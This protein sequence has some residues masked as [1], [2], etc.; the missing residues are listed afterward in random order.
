MHRIYECAKKKA[1]A[2]VEYGINERNL[3]A[4]GELVDICKDIKQME[5]W[6]SKTEN[7]DEAHDDKSMKKP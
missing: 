3:K 1:D 6:H 4:L 7:Y 5:Y 2:I